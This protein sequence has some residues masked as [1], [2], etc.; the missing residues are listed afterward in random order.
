MAGMVSSQ[1]ASLA[2]RRRSLP[3]GIAASAFVR[4]RI[5]LFELNPKSGELINEDKTILLQ[6]QPLKLLLMLI[7]RGGEMVTRYEIQQ[8]LWGNDVI[9]DFDHSINTLVRKL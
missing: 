3:I 8:R 9:I 4:F 5:G 7:D 6:P 2:T 1:N